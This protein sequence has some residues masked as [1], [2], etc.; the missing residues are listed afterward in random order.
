MKE[1]YK[2][3]G[4]RGERRGRRRGKKLR[5]KVDK[6]VMIKIRMGGRRREV[7]EGGM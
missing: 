7:S 6:D 1:E 3:R 2:G 4:E 5:N